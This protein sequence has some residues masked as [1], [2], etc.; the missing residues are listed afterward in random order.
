[1]I[2]EIETDGIQRAMVLL[3]EA[4][5]ARAAIQENIDTVQQELQGVEA[6]LGAAREELRS[7]EA[8]IAISGLHMP[9]DPS[10]VEARIALLER[11][12]RILRVRRE[13]FEQQ[14]LAP[15]EEQ[16]RAAKEAV[17]KE[18]RLVGLQQT[19]SIRMRYREAAARSEERRVGKEC[20]SRWS[21][22]H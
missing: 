5:N 2:T 21:P 1:M 13:I 19:E 8:K 17:R 6:N 12:R 14:D 3:E 9:D 11:H 18:W 7:E 4:Q 16:V 20:R 22:Y 15:A 10:P